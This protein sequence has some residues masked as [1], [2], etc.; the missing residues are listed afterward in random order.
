MEKNT[1]LEI[2]SA[3]PPK[4]LFLYIATRAKVVLLDKINSLGVFLSYLHDGISF[5]SVR[6][7]VFTILLCS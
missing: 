5:P 3:P 7:G 2:K 1:D 4:A 6:G